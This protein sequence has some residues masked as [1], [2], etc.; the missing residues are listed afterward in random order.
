MSLI[1]LIKGGKKKNECV[2]LLHG[3]GR[4]R[5]SLLKL[6]VLLSKEYQVINKTYPSRKHTIEELAKIAIEPVL[7][8]D[9]AHYSKIHFVTHSLGGILV[10]QYLSQHSIK[11]LGN[12]VMLGPPNQGSELV[13]FFQR[14]PALSRLYRA[15]NGPAGT[16]LGT[17]RYSRPI[18]LGSVDFKLG[19]IAGSKNR[20]PIFSRILPGD[21]DGKVSVSSSKVDGM[22]EH[23]VLPVDH[24]FMMLDEQVIK[25][26]EH[27]LIYSKFQS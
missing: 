18:E 26:I 5:F 17:D 13:D 23:L 20:N 2:I 7:N 15:I 25:Q 19:V 9:S 21:S 22:T 11:N 10:R 8:S 27:F 4:S 1:D 12:V 24:T 6:E 3:L 16:Q 14:S